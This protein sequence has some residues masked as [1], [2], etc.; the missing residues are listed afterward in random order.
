MSQV[1][2]I[3]YEDNHCLVVDK[4]AGMLVQPDRTGD[5][6]LLDWARD[7]VRRR[8]AKPGGVF[9]GVV[10]RLDRP[11]S[12]VVLLART[13]KAASRLA[14]QF[15]D[16]TVEKRYWAIVE[17]APETPAG[18]LEDHLVKDGA[19]NRVRVAR[20][21]ERGA[22]A[23][24]LR[25]EVLG[26]RPGGTLLEVRPDTGRPHQIRV[27]LASRGW[28]IAGD[29]RY[30]SHREF[31]RWIALH[32]REIAFRHPTRRETVRVGAGVPPE[33]GELLGA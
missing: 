1:P 29:V 4:P 19:A 8:F 30:G 21:G 5:A 12:G 27:Q 20:A 31:G 3:L 33:W 32:A 10:H 24:R 28:I 11:V 16:G 26:A 13:S 22:R 23:A 14:T 18:E 17:R 25:Y 15:R 9:V 7:D 2:R 6:T